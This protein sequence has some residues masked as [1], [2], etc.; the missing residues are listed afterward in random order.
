MQLLKV[1]E[2]AQ[3]LRYAPSY[4]RKLVMLKKVPHIKLNGAVRFKQEDLDQ[5]IAERRVT[6]TGKGR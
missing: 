4:L 5:Y 3:Y 1:D 6:A 2:A